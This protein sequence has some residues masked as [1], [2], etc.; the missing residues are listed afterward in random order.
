MSSRLPW[1]NICY[2]RRKLCFF[3]YNTILDLFSTVCTLSHK[4]D[5]DLIPLFQYWFYTILSKS[6]SCHRPTRNSCC[7][8]SSSFQTLYWCMIFT[9]ILIFRSTILAIKEPRL[10]KGLCC[11]YYKYNQNC[12]VWRDSIFISVFYCTFLFYYKSSLII[13]NLTFYLKSNIHIP[14]KP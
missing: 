4:F 1:A 14:W 12:Y 5:A 3:H 13:I 7:I 10:M 2:C 11:K 9:T 8:F 6:V